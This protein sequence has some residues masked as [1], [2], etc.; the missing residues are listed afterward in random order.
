MIFGNPNEKPSRVNETPVVSSSLSTSRRYL[1]DPVSSNVNKS[2]NPLVPL[3]LLLLFISNSA[4]TTTMH[5]NTNKMY[6]WYTNNVTKPIMIKIFII[7]NVVEVS[8]T[9]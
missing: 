2:F 9:L 8:N 7:E 4:D 6:C 3:S 1:D 5:N